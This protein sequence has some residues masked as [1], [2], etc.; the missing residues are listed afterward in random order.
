MRPAPTS[1]LTD[2]L[3]IG[4]F[5]LRCGVAHY[6]TPAVPFAWV[7]LSASETAVLFPRGRDLFEDGEEILNLL[8]DLLLIH[9]RLSNLGA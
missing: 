8:V 6:T 9:H 2:A 5:L 4:T 3:P 7:T 1:E